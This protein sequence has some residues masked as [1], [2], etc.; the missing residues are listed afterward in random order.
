MANTPTIIAP[1]EPLVDSTGK[2]T[3]AWFRALSGLFGNSGTVATPLVVAPSVFL[4]EGTVSSG[5]T[6]SSPDLPAGTLIG[7]SDTI[8]G[9]ASTLDIGPSLLLSAGT[10]SVAPIPAGMLSGNSGTAAAPPGP[11]E[12]AGNLILSGG[13]LIGT[14][15]TDDETLLYSIRD[16]RGQIAT[17]DHHVAALETLL[18]S[19]PDRSGEI[20]TLDRKVNN[21]PTLARFWFGHA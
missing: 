10:L 14:A 16:T 15:N 12:V 21:A 5:G 3:H 18:H 17:K 1:R 8:A 13:T 7:N 4:N 9:Q 20:A 19:L 11:I 2:I 6:I